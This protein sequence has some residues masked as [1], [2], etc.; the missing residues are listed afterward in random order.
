MQHAC[1]EHLQCRTEPHFVGKVRTKL[2]AWLLA[3]QYPKEAK[4]EIEAIVSVYQGEGWKLS[5]EIQTRI[6]EDWYQQTTALPDNRALYQQFQDLA[7]D[8]LVWGCARGSDRGRLC[9]P[10]KGRVVFRG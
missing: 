5:P 7:E 10:G 3:N 8:I 9:E 2:A 1:V 4:T 6:K